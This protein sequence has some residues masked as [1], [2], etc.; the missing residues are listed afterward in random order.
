MH[1]SDGVLPMSVTV[2]GYAASAAL[3]AWSARRTRSETLPK[4]A[5]VTAAFFVASLIHI[6][7][8]PTSVHLLIPGLAG[9][10]LGPSA[11]LAVGLGLLLQSILF[12][13]GGLTA[14]GAN[15]LMMGVP[16]LICGVFFQR[17]K[18]RTRSRQSIVGGIA[19]ALGTAMAALILALLLAAGGED[20]FGVAKIALAAHVPVI[21]I[22]GAVSAF[23]IG[24]LARV[25]PEM[26]EPV[27]AGGADDTHDT[28]PRDPS[29]H[30]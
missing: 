5:V 6:P 12:Q 16:A 21:L 7:F 11:F 19:G 30:G 14:L 10:L 2:G 1:I 24:F 9:A 13:F 15:A 18:G 22:E 23:T 29:A 28:A 17:L 4:V 8:G 20:F 26:L 3:A 25:K 27:F